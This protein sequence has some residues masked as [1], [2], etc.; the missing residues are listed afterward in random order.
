MSSSKKIN[1][2]RSTPS[3]QEDAGVTKAASHN[4]PTDVAGDEILDS[5]DQGIN[6]R[7]DVKQ[8]CIIINRYPYISSAK[9]RA[10]VLLQ[11]VLISRTD[12]LGVSDIISGTEANGKDRTASCACADICTYMI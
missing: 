7:S 5:R 10:L 11:Q 12:I 8:R 6:V 3:S 4:A 2:R 1:S 9:Q